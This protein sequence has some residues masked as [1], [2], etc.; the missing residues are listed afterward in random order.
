MRSE[1]IMEQQQ[2]KIS[3]DAILEWSLAEMDRLLKELL[4]SDDKSKAPRNS[5]TP[6]PSPCSTDNELADQWSGPHVPAK[7]GG[8][9]WAS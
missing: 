7:H 4:D 9:Y 1:F 3:A 8:L 5:T 2:E 6:P